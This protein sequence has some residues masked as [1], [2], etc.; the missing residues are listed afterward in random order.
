MTTLRCQDVSIRLHKR[1]V[2]RDFS[3]QVEPGSWLCLIGP[4]G[5]GK[6]SL[7]KAVAGLIKYNGSVTIGEEAINKLKARRRSQLI[8]YVPQAPIFPLGMS[9]FEYVLL[10]RNP[11]VSHFGYET[12]ED[13]H[14]VANVLERLE[15][16]SLATRDVSEMSGGE[17]QRFAIA[18]AIA[19]GSPVLLLDEPTSAL[20]LGNQQLALELVERL[21]VEMGITVISAMHDLTL[22][23][24]YSD[25]LLL[26]HE[27]NTVV[28]GNADE[29]LQ[30]E[31]LS[32][33]YGAAVRV[34][35]ADDGTVVVLP[36]RNRDVLP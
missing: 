13:R 9:G 4:N 32:E 33:F 25:Q 12:T 27:G 29:V 19:Q 15:L 31:T 7:L 5:A 20:D 16:D 3:A 17:R 34:H 28:M 14:I 8:S 26:L 22:A 10:G 1:T 6:S 11:Y 23:G 2:V 21:R 35:R 18:R 36:I 24:L 30:A